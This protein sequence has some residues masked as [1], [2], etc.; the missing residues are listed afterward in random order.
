MQ[1]SDWKGGQEH[2]EDILCVAY[3]GPN[4]LATGSY[5]G[6]IIV[7][8]LG[9]EQVSKRLHERSRRMMLKSQGKNNMVSMSREVSY[10]LQI[11][12]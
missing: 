5:D 1:P 2:L 11:L 4:I 8:N 6:E 10:M 12:K 3:S 7:W 9:S